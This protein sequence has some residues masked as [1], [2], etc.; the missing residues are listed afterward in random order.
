MDRNETVTKTSWEQGRDSSSMKD[1]GH[2]ILVHPTI[3]SAEHV[4]VLHP[5]P[6]GKD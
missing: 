1:H 3:P 6:F 4:H 2:W 5:S